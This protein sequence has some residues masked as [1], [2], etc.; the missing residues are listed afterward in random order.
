VCTPD[1]SF[2]PVL[3]TLL[4]ALI[5]PLH[6]ASLQAISALVWALL[7]SQSLHTSDLSRALPEL[8]T[9]GARQ[10]MRRVRRGLDRSPLLSVCLTP[11]LVRVALRL[12]DLADLVDRHD[13]DP[14]VQD[15]IGHDPIVLVLDS[16]R[17]LHWEVFTLGVGFHGRVL[18][19]AWAI[20]PYP[21]PKHQF[22]PTV[23]ALLERTL[24]SW[25]SERSVHLVADRGFPS[26]KLF[27]ALETWRTRLP[28]GYTIRLRAGDWVHLA[29]GKSVRLAD[30]LKLAAAKSNAAGWTSLQASYCHRGKQSPSALL[31]LGRSQPVYP[32]H[33]RGPADEARRLARA[34]RRQ[35]HLLSKAQPQAPD[36][37]RF[38]ILLSSC[39]TIEEAR[40]FYERRFQTEGM[41]R[42][43]KAWGLATVAA[44]ERDP[45]HL[46]GLIGLAILGYLV[47]AALGQ[48][49]KG[50][51]AG[52][53]F[54]PTLGSATAQA[55]QRQLQWC[56]TDRLSVFWRGRQVLQDRA[57]DWLPWLRTSLDDLTRQLAD[58]AINHAHQPR[59]HPHPPPLAKEAA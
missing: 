17:C 21:W 39:Q 52:C 55:C 46:D 59:R 10:A 50:A 32:S 1:M 31:V 54:E 23:V 20:L 27:N 47:Q 24:I 43:L 3:S 41:Y 5:G 2:Y 18:P 37:D 29:D 12:V 53:A 22:T 6:A 9:K 16:T 44:H 57:F 14:I 35:A 26:L 42:D 7:L 25:P 19:I 56:T 15:P 45:R 4:G 58:P 30:L 34:R 13:H 11:R 36:T 48:A 38:W 8:K 33:Q 49:A 28:L 51:V 40:G